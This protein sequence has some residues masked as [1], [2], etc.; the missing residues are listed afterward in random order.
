MRCSSTRRRSRTATILRKKASI[1]TVFSCV[2][3]LPGFM[4]SWP[5]VQRSPIAP[6][7]D[8]SALSTARTACTILRRS[9][10]SSGM[11]LLRGPRRRR[12]RG[13]GPPDSA[14]GWT[15]RP[16]RG[17]PPWLAFY[18]D[19]RPTLNPQ[20][21][22]QLPQTGPRRVHQAGHVPVRVAVLVHELVHVRD[23]LEGEG[24]GEARVDLAGRDQVV[25]RLRLLVV[26]EVRALEA[27]LAHPEVAEVGDRG[28][29]ARAG[30]DDDHAARVADEDRGRHGVLARVLEDDAGAPALAHHLPEGGAE[31]ARAL[32]PLAVPLRVLPVRRHAPVGGL[33]AV[34]AALGAEARA[35]LDL[36]VARDD[37][38]RDA[39]HRA[40]DLDRL[41]AEAAGAAPDEDHV[42]RP[43]RVRRPG[44]EHAI[45]GRPDQHVCG[46]GV[47]GELGRLRQALVRLHARELREAAPAGLVAPDAKARAEHRIGA[48]LDDRIILAPHPAVDHDLVAEL[49]VA[50]RAAHLPH[51]PRG[52]A[53]ADV[54]GVGVWKVGVLL[55]ALDHVDRGAE[56]GPDVVVVDAGGHDPDQHL[57]GPELR[58]HLDLLHLE[59][60]GRLAEAV[61]A[62][63]LGEHPPWHLA[64]RPRLAELVEP[65]L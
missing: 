59:G 4:T 46:R 30:A 39:A 52:V 49:H 50:D 61:L 9:S 5:P 54:E 45:R 28:V 1:G 23:L 22:R 27:L 58:R 6:D 14:C 21:S 48:R 25:Q 29:A 11:A 63:E 2:P 44:A 12:S 62:H 13:R 31:G 60:P 34:D 24:L 10:S 16:A 56:R 40:R 42:A 51:D 41:A 15:R 57:L 53:P 43:D 8:C 37:R 64:E 20:S 32:Q 18:G 65:F 33:L 47:P 17:A 36:V 7:T 3:A 19:E 35:E 55:P 26:G 38:D